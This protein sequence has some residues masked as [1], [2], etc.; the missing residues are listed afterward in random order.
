M[1]KGII[2]SRGIGD[3]IIALPIAKHYHNK[4]Y[5]I[6]WP[7]C[8]EF[9]GS[10]EHTVP[11]V[12]W[13]GIKTDERGDYFLKEPM[14]VFK[15]HGIEQRE[16][17]YLYQYLNSHPE[18]TNEELFNILKFD[19]YKYWV[20]GVPFVNKWTLSECI[21][22]DL[23][24]E[25]SLLL[26]LGITGEYVVVHKTGSNFRVDIDVNW[27][28]KD[29]QIIDVDDHLTDNVFDWIGV[30]EG[31]RAFVGVDSSF[32]NLVDCL[33]IDTDRYW[34]RRSPWDLTPVLGGTWKL[35]QSNLPYGDGKRIEL[36]AEV[37]RKKRNA[38]VQMFTQVPF[39]MN[40]KGIPTSFLGALKDQ[41]GSYR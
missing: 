17:L 37:E 34:I 3:I 21:T 7:I 25:K 32:A 40:K 5:E 14:R 20:A 35:L 28:G 12:T 33:N 39:D 9:L 4:G 27:F 31:A 1:K 26:A 30:L 24:R 22:R 38:N 41:K 16:I 2:Q 36:A 13:V 15:E 6:V 19:Q 29:V 11:W 23:E 8:E 18:L 10:F